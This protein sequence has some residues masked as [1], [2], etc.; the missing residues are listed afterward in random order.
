MKNKTENGLEEN[1][2]INRQD[3]IEP[4]ENN[5]TINKILA[6]SKRDGPMMIICLIAV[7]ICVGCLFFINSERQTY[8]E[9]W[10][11]FIKQD[12]YC[13]SMNDSIY[14]T[15]QFDMTKFMEAYNNGSTNTITNS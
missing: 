15:Q 7:L 4:L 10:I 8:N 12:C 6:W 2:S 1:N 3:V 11:K 9:A 13:H 5:E 14:K